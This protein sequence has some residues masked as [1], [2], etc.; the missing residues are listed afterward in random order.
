MVQK[1]F[2]ATDVN[3]IYIPVRGSFCSDLGRC[4]YFVLL[5]EEFY[6]DDF[7]TNFGQVKILMEGKRFRVDVKNETPE[8]VMF[9][10]PI[11]FVSN[12]PPYG[13]DDSFVMRCVVVNADRKW[14]RNGEEFVDWED[15]MD[16]AE[17]VFAPPV[18]E[19]VTLSSD[20]DDDD[21]DEKENRRP[22]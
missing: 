5:F 18:Y 14:N 2:R 17:E 3:D 11:T 20:D 16:A 1:L 15:K 13:F 6:Y 12:E 4:T 8:Y 7:K 21:D 10:G 22:V 19:V 9:D